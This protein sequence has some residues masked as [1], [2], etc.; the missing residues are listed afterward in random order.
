MWKE[1]SDVDDYISLM[2]VLG[3]LWQFTDNVNLLTYLLSFFLFFSFFLSFFLSLFMVQSPSWE[4]NRFLAS[5]GTPCILWNPKVYY[6]IHKSLPPVPCLSLIDPL[7][8]HPT[9]WRSILIL[10]SHLCLGLSSGLFPSS[11]LHQNRVCTSSMPPYVL[12]ALPISI[13]LI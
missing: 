5:Q 12:H 3:K 2:A 11:F 8:P 13:F 7:H 10:S 4:A 9:S 6:H 1:C